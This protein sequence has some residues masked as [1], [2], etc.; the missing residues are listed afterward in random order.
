MDQSEIQ[1][2][3]AKTWELVCFPLTNIAT[4]A[5]LMLMNFISYL[6]VGNY[7]ILVGVASVIITGSRI[8]DAVTDPIIGFIIDRTN[9][10]LGKFRPMIL[11]GYMIMVISLL[12]MFFVGIGGGIVVFSVLYALYIIGYTFQTACFKA[13]LASLTNDP[14]QRPI[15]ARFNAIYNLLFASGFA[16]YVSNYIVMNTGVLSSAVCRKCVLLLLFFRVF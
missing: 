3:R 4:N 6:A 16:F 5:F 11:L 8:F 9:G 15:S 13:G 2:N 7:G 1:Y 14:L 12:L 10:R